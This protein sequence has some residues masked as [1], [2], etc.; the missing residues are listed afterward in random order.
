VGDL[1]QASSTGVG[2]LVHSDCPRP[3]YT[4]WQLRPGPCQPVELPSSGHAAAL[5]EANQSWT[6][7]SPGTIT[8]KSGAALAV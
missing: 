6:A 1:L 3:R 8:H 7:T 2:K 5:R 4:T